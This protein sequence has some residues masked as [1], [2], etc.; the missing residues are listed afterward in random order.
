MQPIENSQSY[1]PVIQGG[2]ELP[3]TT[4]VAFTLN[5]NYQAVLP[6]SSSDIEG[7]LIA[8]GKYYAMKLAMILG[9][10]KS[11]NEDALFPIT[12]ILRPYIEPT[13]LN[14]PTPTLSS[15]ETTPLI[16]NDNERAEFEHADMQEESFFRFLD[17]LESGAYAADDVMAEE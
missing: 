14:V 17:E 6:N 4:K 7:L 1:L 5:G 13:E 2:N 16:S 3:K 8:A 15:R 11:L 10:L 9:D 12:L